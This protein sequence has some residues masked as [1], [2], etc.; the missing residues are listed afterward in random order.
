[1]AAFSVSSDESLGLFATHEMSLEDV[2]MR[3]LG[4]SW[5]VSA[6]NLANSYLLRRVAPAR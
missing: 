5:K 4:S 1:M 6:R 3:G 2:G